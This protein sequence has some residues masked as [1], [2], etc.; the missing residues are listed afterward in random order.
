MAYSGAMTM[1]SGKKLYPDNDIAFSILMI[2]LAIVVFAGIALNRRGRRT[3]AAMIIAFT[4]A[5]LIFVSQFIQI[6]EVIYYTGCSLLLFGVWVNG[7]FLHFFQR[8]RKRFQL[9]SIT[10]F[11]EI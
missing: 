11:Y 2:A 8:M 9:F 3:R 4:G 1:C 10:K 5:L 6:S 7:S